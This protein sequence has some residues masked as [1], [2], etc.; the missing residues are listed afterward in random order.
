MS[1]VPGRNTCGGAFL[2]SP[3]TNLGDILP[4]R[5]TS[6]QKGSVACSPPSGGPALRERADEELRRLVN[7]AEQRCVGE[8]DWND[9]DRDG[10]GP[11][12][13]RAAAFRRLAIIEQ[14]LHA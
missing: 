11:Q 5:R 3:I 10:R 2:E 14:T 12:R 13:Q 1:S 6:C 9:R 4:D 8:D 7:G